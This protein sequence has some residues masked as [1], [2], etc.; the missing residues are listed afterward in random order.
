MTKYL[1]NAWKNNMFHFQTVLTVTFSLFLARIFLQFP[2]I[3]SE[4]FVLSKKLILFLNENT[5]NNA[6]WKHASPFKMQCYS[7]FHREVD[8]VLEQD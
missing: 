1:L 5:I 2:C 3:A 4:L 6:G 7:S 8:Q